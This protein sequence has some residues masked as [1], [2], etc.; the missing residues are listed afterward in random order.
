MSKT[1]KPW[2]ASSLD[3]RTEFDSSRLVGVEWEYNWVARQTSKYGYEHGVSSNR[4]LKA[5][6]KKWRGDI[7]EDGS[8]GYEAV[9]APL[10]GNH[11]APCLQ[12]L[13]QVFNNE[14]VSID[15]QCSIHVHVDAADFSWNDMYRLLWVYSQVEWALFSL[16]GPKR[17][18]SSYCRPCGKK[19]REVLARRFVMKN[20]AA[21][22]RDQVLNTVYSG[23]YHHRRILRLT[24]IEW[25]RRADRR[26]EARYKALNICPWLYA[27]KKRIKTLKTFEFRLH[28]KTK[29]AERV[30]GWTKLLA[31]LVDWV[32]QAEDKDVHQLPSNGLLA[33][34]AMCPQSRAW[35]LQQANKWDGR[36]WNNI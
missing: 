6:C 23:R 9:T 31:E 5:W 30:I 29:D 15:R 24:G 4:E 16:A 13:G 2:R 17:K 25:Y 18:S 21:N 27:T 22:I 34:F 10:A 33:L 3:E 32:H 26:D 28:Q 11:I 36:D 12:E 1:A 7:H 35:L 8:C 19:Y 14:T 20:G